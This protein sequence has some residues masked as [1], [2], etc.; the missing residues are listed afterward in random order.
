MIDYC[1]GRFFELASAATEPMEASWGV[2]TTAGCDGGRP[3]LWPWHEARLRASLGQLAPNVS[4]DLPDEVTVSQLLADREQHGPARLRLV[5]RRTGTTKTWRVEVCV[6]AL[7]EDSV[8]PDTA[9]VVLEPVV[10]SAPPP[11]AG[12]KTLARMPWDHARESV[13]RAGADDAVLVDSGGWLLETSVANL[14]L[15]QGDELA[16]PPAPDACLPGVMRRLL[17][18]I[19]HEVG[20]EATARRVHVSELARADEVWISNAVLG[21]RRVRAVASHHWTD[22]P[23]HRRLAQ[24]GLLAPGWDLTFIKRL[25][26]W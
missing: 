4:L 11:W 19:A 10:W 7:A 6:A 1:D 18:E 20:L 9:P 25:R 24:R 5:V 15:R 22:W 14:W 13:R 23:G 21:V 17:L 26:K 12:H 8:G 3:L 2:F 16:T